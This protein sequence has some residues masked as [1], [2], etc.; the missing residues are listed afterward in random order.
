MEIIIIYLTLIVSLSMALML[1]Y[2][3]I[4]INFVAHL[5]G[6]LFVHNIRMHLE[7]RRDKAIAVKGNTYYP[8]H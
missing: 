5:I 4:T 6:I 2:I 8:M 3:S 1:S 7:W